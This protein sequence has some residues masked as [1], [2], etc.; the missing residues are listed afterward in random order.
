MR[1]CML[2]A[3][4]T[5]ACLLALAVALLTLLSCNAVFGATTLHVDAKN[6]SAGKGSPESPF[7]SLQAAIDA[8]GDGDTIKVAAGKYAPI[9]IKQKAVLLYGGYPGG[10]DY[11]SGKSGD[12]TTRDRD[13]HETRIAGTGNENVITLDECGASRIDGFYISGGKRGISS[14][15]WPF[16]KQHPV[17]N[18]NVIEDNKG[19]ADSEGGAMW[20]KT[21]VTLTRN[22]IRRNEAGK[23][24]ALACFSTEVNV[25]GNLITDN[26]GLG[27][28][29][30]GLYV[31]ANV[32]NVTHNLFSGNVTGYKGT[33][34]VGGALI[35]LGNGTVAR[36]AGNIYT[37]NSA[38]KRGA[39][40]FID[41]EAV[42]TIE[43][44]IIYG[45]PCGNAGGTAIAIDGLDE[46]KRSKATIKN[47]TVFGHDCPGEG[48]GVQVENAEVEV[49]SSIF[50]GNSD[51]FGTLGN[52][53]LTVHHTISKETIAGEGNS[54]DD[55]LLADAK[56][57]DFHLRSSVGRFKAGSWVKD[58]EHSPAIDA[59][60]PAGAHDSEPSPNGGRVDAGAFG[61]TTE[62]SKSKKAGGSDAPSKTANPAPG[63]SGMASASGSGTVPVPSAVPSSPPPSSQPGQ[64]GCQGCA[65]SGRA[66]SGWLAL[67]ALGALL[68]RMRRRLAR[69]DQRAR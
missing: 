8:A 56:A 59:G 32:V 25:E 16:D 13:K 37:A 57:G 49:S 39:A 2:H 63:P 55:P 33:Y 60:D 5:R 14:D 38:P 17:I 24:A 41:D 27:D 23:G 22:T 6:Q 67:V 20:C 34:G 52:A 68:I 42:A 65:A 53:Q 21:K 4:Q 43:N 26:I 28:H 29:G 62:A 64:Q 46:N 69:S 31:G 45:N 19:P 15:G 44:E 48:N 36:L 3:L 9:T 66:P 54:N 40:I 18:D 30:G 47:V 7:Q 61:N 11:A 51:D 50:W 10:S 35:I 12:F 58:K 1:P